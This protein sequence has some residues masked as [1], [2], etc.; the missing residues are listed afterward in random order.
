MKLNCD[1]TENV[2]KI[3]IVYFKGIMK[4][5]PLK[6]VLNTIIFFSY[7]SSIYKDYLKL[8]DEYDF[9]TEHYASITILLH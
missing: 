9:R 2:K 4:I 7:Y 1:L 5:F 6:G 3:S 8:P